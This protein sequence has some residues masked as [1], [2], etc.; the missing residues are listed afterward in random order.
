MGLRPEQGRRCQS[1]RCPK[2]LDPYFISK[3]SAIWT[4]FPEARLLLR[5][6]GFGVCFSDNANNLWLATLVTLK[7]MWWGFLVGHEPRAS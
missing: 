6:G 4:Q 3:P 2:I 1:P 7:N 5:Q